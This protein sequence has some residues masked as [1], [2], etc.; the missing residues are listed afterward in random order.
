MPILDLRGKRAELSAM[1]DTLG[2]DIKRSFVTESTSRNEL[3]HESVRSLTTWLSDIWVVVYEHQ[4]D[5]ELAHDCLLFVIEKL[6]QIA[7]LRS[8][9]VSS[10]HCDHVERFH[11]FS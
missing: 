3:L 7:N 11:I 8:G 6:D 2:K 4:V 5:F 9:F 1:L 10:L